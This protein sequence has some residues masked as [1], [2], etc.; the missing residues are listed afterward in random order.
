METLL[1]LLLIIVLGVGIGIAAKVFF[2]SCIDI[3]NDI[4]KHSN[5]KKAVND[6]SSQYMDYKTKY[7]SLYYEYLNEGSKKK[8]EYLSNICEKHQI[9][10][11]ETKQCYALSKDETRLLVFS[12]IPAQKDFIGETEASTYPPS[13]FRIVEHHNINVSKILYFVKDGDISYTTSVSGGGVNIKGAVAGAVIAGGAGAIIGSRNEIS[14]K[15]IKHDNRKVI[16]KFTDGKEKSFPIDDYDCL[17]KIIPKKEFNYIHMYKN[18]NRQK[19][20]SPR[21]SQRRK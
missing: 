1:W 11:N 17:L 15:T 19:N 8:R 3:K 5:H 13:P 9:W 12:F 20:S 4:T 14:S 10:N 2:D 16:M 7:D 6:F 21:V 18:K